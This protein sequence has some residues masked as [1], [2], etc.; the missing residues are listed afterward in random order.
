MAVALPTM[1]RRPSPFPSDTP[2]C[3]WEVEL[4]AVE[5][6]GAGGG[7]I[8]EELREMALPFPEF[9]SPMANGAGPRRAVLCVLCSFLGRCLGSPT[10]TRRVQG[11]SSLCVADPPPT[12]RRSFRAP[13]RQRP[14]RRE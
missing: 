7:N 13:R 1:G 9:A 8:T 6:L 12:R 2:H 4:E 14:R 11:A 3:R 5:V 10:L